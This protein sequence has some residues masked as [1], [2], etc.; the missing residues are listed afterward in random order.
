MSPTAKLEPRLTP[1]SPEDA[2]ILRAFFKD[3]GYNLD[4]LRAGFPLADATSFRYRKN[5]LARNGDPSTLDVMLQWFTFGTAVSIETANRMI[6]AHIIALAEACGL[7]V[8]EQDS[9]RPLVRLSPFDD[10]LI[11]SD[12]ASKLDQDA[13]DLIIWPNPTTNHI[14]NAAIRPKTGSVLDLGCGPGTLSVACAAPSVSVTATDINPR[15]AAFTEFNARLNGAGFIECRTG[16][17]FEPVAGEKFDLILCNPPFFLVPSTGLLYCENPM[18][19]DGFARS[20]MRQAP[21]HLNESGFFQMMCEWADLAGTPWRDRLREWAEGIGCDVWILK[22]YTMNPLAYGKERCEQRPGDPAAADAAFGDW[23]EYYREKGIEAVHGGFITL[24][25]RSGK[26]WIR[27]VEDSSI[28]AAHPFGD[29]LLDGFAA[30]DLIEGTDEDLLSA[31]LRLDDR[32]RLGQF[33]RREGSKW[34]QTKLTLTIP[35]APGT[36]MDLA[37]SVAEFLGKFDGT[38]NLREL[39]L[40]L[41]QT[42]DVDEPKVIA[43]CLAITRKLLE[44]GFLANAIE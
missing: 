6:P 10:L 3:A 7:L 28:T 30:Q 8:R 25:R 41:A 14:W 29:L 23:I 43:E 37:P 38:R 24:R 34:T 22:I 16:D 20:L 13:S 35:G 32:A 31:R 27:I 42:M 15:A 12:P 44:R 9:L 17:C 18:E 36:E 21:A 19:L 39:S 40:D 5:L 4:A 2:K 11:A 1:P 26:N 33:L